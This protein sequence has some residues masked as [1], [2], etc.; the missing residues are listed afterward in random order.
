M[1]KR[2]A[3]ITVALFAGAALFS[4]AVLAK[5]DGESK[6]E[7]RRQ[8]RMAKK[9]NTMFD[10]IDATKVQRA[11]ITARIAAVRPQMKA[12]R[13]VTK[14]HA[15][16]IKT[17]ILSPK[18]DAKLMHKHINDASTT[19][20]KNMATIT[21]T[22]IAIHGDLTQAQRIKLAKQWDTPYREFKGSWFID[23]GLDRMLAKL[24]ATKTQRKVA[25]TQKNA[26]VKSAAGLIKNMHPIKQKLLKQW[27]S[28][29]VDRKTVDTLVNRA[30][31][32]M[33]Q[34]AHDTTDSVLIFTKTL[35][36][37]QRKQ[38][39]TMLKNRR[40]SYK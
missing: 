10:D 28:E 16:A 40:K 35:S 34:F 37:K 3:L 26:I 23:R 32:L 18:P 8:K 2:I 25:E 17:I 33:T 19:T 36:D 29:K 6:Y 22:A 24:D 14:T 7:T 31:L 21:S 11:K 30:G 13:K 5:P 20:M 39:S 15:K 4:T 1:S 27:K 38:A 12:A 9:L